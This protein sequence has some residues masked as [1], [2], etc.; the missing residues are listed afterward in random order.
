M[1]FGGSLIAGL[2]SGTLAGILLCSVALAHNPQ[3]EFADPA[4]G[5][6]TVDLYWPFGLT[7]AMVGGP[8]TAVLTLIGFLRRGDN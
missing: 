5:S 1:S 6:Y 2:L 4:T 3:G 8:I 7:V